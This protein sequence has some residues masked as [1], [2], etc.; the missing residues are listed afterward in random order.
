MLQKR[1]LDV[2]IVIG[3]MIALSGDP[4]VPPLLYLTAACV[5]VVF[6]CA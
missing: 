4:V 1:T 5:S 2:L 6:V 3:G